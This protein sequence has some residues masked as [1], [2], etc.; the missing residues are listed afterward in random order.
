MIVKS[1]LLVHIFLFGALYAFYA[2]MYVHFTFMMY[3]YYLFLLLNGFIRNAAI[4][5]IPPFFMLLE[6]MRIA[7][8][9]FLL[10]P[11]LYSAFCNI[12]LP[13]NIYIVYIHL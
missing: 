1:Y 5:P 2:P 9:H 11:T 4:M 12:L 7:F 8:K 13:D 3:S 10:M 6:L